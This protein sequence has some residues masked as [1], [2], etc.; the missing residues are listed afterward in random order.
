MAGSGLLYNSVGYLFVF[1]NNFVYCVL[2]IGWLFVFALT[3]VT[4][5]IY[6]WLGCKCLLLRISFNLS[7][8]CFR[9]L[10]GLFVYLI[11]FC[12]LVGLF[13]CVIL[14]VVCWLFD[15]CLSGVGIA[16][17][18]MICCL[19]LC[20][21][22]WDIWLIIVLRYSDTLVVCVCFVLIILIWGGVAF[23]CYLLF[24]LW[25]VIL[26]C[27]TC[28][29]CCLCF[30]LRFICL[31]C[32]RLWFGCFICMFGVFCVWNDVLGLV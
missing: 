23:L 29:G 28:L 5:V 10:S 19:G 9:V 11:L 18:P 8:L 17:L 20:C 3:G 21:M 14:L 6:C 26:C 25:F 15:L 2:F 1:I 12:F 31:G 22:F 4:L 24:W 13:A 7:V 16:C 30:D 27:V 32:F